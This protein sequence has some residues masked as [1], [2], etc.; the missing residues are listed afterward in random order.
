MSVGKQVLAANANQDGVPLRERGHY[1]SSSAIFFLSG[2]GDIAQ[3]ILIRLGDAFAETGLRLPSE[4]LKAR[5][6]EQL[7]C[8]A[9]GLEGI[10]NQFAAE[11]DDLGDQFRGFA[12]GNLIADADVNEFPDIRR[13]FRR[14]PAWPT[15]R[16]Y[17]RAMVRNRLR[18]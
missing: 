12:D 16:R 3:E 1:E 4:S 6:V 11:S 10:E 2:L 8:R 7:T 18:N 9:V 5:H 15:H 14:S 17:H 13:S